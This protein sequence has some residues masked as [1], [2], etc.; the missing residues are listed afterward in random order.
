M[1]AVS[2]AG[3]TIGDVPASSAE[4]RPIEWQTTPYN[5]SC[6]IEQNLAF[7]DKSPVYLR[8]GQPKSTV[9]YV[10]DKTETYVIV[11]NQPLFAGTLK[12]PYVANFVPSSTFETDSSN[13]L[14]VEATGATFS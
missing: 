13:I 3:N 8:V 2:F 11:Y 5:G 14:T 12:F 9:N 1:G 7:Y 6:D 4:L 10:F